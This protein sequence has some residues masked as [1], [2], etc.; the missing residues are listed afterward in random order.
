IV[1]VGAQRLERA[2][3]HAVA[4]RGFQPM[5]R[6]DD[7]GVDILEPERNRAALNLLDRG[8]AINSLTSVSL[9]VTAAA[10]AIAGLTRWVRAPGPWRPTKLRLLVDAQR[11]PVGT[12]SGFIAR[13]AEQP[14]S[15]HSRPASMK[16]RS[17]PSASAC[18]FTRPEPGTTIAHLTFGAFLR[19]LMTAAAARMSSMRL[20]VQLPMKIFSTGT[21]CIRIPGSSP[22]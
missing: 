13:H 18:R 21:S 17:S 7:V 9:P 3:A 15:R 4:R 2:L 8:H 20:V 19:P 11:S 16:M 14:G 12:L 5:R 22:I 10:A 1:G 6:D